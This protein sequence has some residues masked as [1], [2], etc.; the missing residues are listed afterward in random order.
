V[1]VYFLKENASSSSI[2]Q[3]VINHYSRYFISKAV[4]LSNTLAPDQDGKL[5]LLWTEVCI[6]TAGELENKHGGPPPEKKYG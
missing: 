2:L 5:A 3:Y 6:V 1:P 4:H